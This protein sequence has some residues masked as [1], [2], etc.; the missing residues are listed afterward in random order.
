MSMQIETYCVMP[1]GIFSSHLFTVTTESAFTRMCKQ[2]ALTLLLSANDRPF[3]VHV[4]GVGVLS[5]KAMVIGAG[6]DR[7]VGAINCDLICINIEPGHPYYI[8]LQKKLDCA[9][10]LLF[11][12]GH[13]ASLSNEL[14]A[15][16]EHK[17][18]AAET[19]KGIEA[20][21][22]AAGNRTRLYGTIDPRISDVLTRIQASLPQKILLSDLAQSVGLS[23]D[24][25]SHLFVET[26]GTQLRSYILWQRYKLALAHISDSAA[27]TPLAYDCGFS[28]AA[29]MSR[30]F[31]NFFGI[32]PS[33]VAR[34]GFVQDF[35]AHA[36]N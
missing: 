18:G 5:V 24:R 8:R 25:L 32:S 19:K 23:P 33:V 31:V 6:Q 10:V 13:F 34:S 2:P 35:E 14:R 4:A 29:H 16:F 1:R 21:I 26:V 30:A 28:D 17:G 9:P 12:E 3:Q 22:E 36:M 15:V 20:L 7:R 27:L 11:S